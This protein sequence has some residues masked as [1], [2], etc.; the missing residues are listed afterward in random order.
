MRSMFG[1]EVPEGRPEGPGFPRRYGLP[2]G[3]KALGFLGGTVGLPHLRFSI[4]SKIA[5]IADIAGGLS[6]PLLVT[7]APTKQD[8]RS[9]IQNQGE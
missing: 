1:D 6:L 5:S 4:L 3:H 7:N 8:M 9:P 2:Q